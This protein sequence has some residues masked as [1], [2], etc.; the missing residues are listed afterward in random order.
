MRPQPPLWVTH[1]HLLDRVLGV[2]RRR[3][4]LAYVTIAGGLHLLGPAIRRGAAAATA[5]AL[6]TA[7]LMLVLF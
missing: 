3:R 7:A 1:R 6:G 2:S 4:R 5:A